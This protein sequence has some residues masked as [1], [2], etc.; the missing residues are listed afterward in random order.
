MR[1]RHG[2]LSADGVVATERGAIR[3]GRARVPQRV[4]VIHAYDR[5]GPACDLV[6]VRDSQVVAGLEA[7]ARTLGIACVGNR[8]AEDHVIERVD[9]NARQSRDGLRAAYG[10]ALREPAQRRA[11]QRDLPPSRIS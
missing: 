6:P 11:R 7:C 10:R 4:T 2:F 1:D 3:Y 8:E 5:L 9:A